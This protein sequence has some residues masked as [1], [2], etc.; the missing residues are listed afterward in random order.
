MRY[1]E[2]IRI[3][4]SGIPTYGDKYQT[5]GSHNEYSHN[6]IIEIDNSKYIILFETT[7]NWRLMCKF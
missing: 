3:S 7:Q 5:I 6:D 2:A 4:R 1:Y